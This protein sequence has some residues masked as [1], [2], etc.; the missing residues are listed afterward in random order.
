METSN[1]SLITTTTKRGAFTLIELLVVIAIIAILAAML[2]PA[3]AK[4][5]TKAKT[6]KCVNN[7]KQIAL[8]YILY[9]GD[10]NDYLPVCAYQYKSGSYAP[11]QWFAEISSF[12]GINGSGSV[13]NVSATNSIAAC[14]MANIQGQIPATSYGAGSFGG[15]G[16][17]FAYLGF[18]DPDTSNS[19][20]GRQKSTIV[21]KPSDTFVNG[22]S[23]DQTPK[24][25]LKWDQFGYLY[26]YFSPAPAPGPLPTGGAYIRHGNG[27][28]DIYSFM[29][30]HAVFMN[31]TN[32]VYGN[33]N[34]VYYLQAKK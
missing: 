15:Y 25:T 33:R 28:G 29:D 5:K 4:A 8:G 13:T 22:D 17:N 26:P 14:P 1:K 23:L 10:R 2:L 11:S 31:W 9:A 27:K 3:L 24:N 18:I 16:A 19:G 7:Q 21:T 34:P 30:G 6:I 12:L 20:Y 32:I